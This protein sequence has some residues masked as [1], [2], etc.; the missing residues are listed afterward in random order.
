MP[1][2]AALELTG[3]RTPPLFLR[4]DLI[5][6]GIA[7]DGD[8]GEWGSGKGEGRGGVRLSL[9]LSLSP[10]KVDKKGLG[11][12][13]VFFVFLF[14]SLPFPS[15]AVIIRVWCVGNCYYLIAGIRKTVVG[16]HSNVT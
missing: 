14:S 10:G 9:S 3:A 13:G 16:T 5:M 4:R 15:S 6:A 1:E 12:G 8:V 11:E 7:G 2:L